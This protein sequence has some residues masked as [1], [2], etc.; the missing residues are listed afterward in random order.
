[1]MD[2]KWRPMFIMAVIA[3]G[4]FTAI[5]IFKDAIN[6]RRNW[7]DRCV[8]EQWESTGEHRVDMRAYCLAKYRQTR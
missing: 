6:G 4:A 7:I 1:M 3:V 2:K 8:V 5:F